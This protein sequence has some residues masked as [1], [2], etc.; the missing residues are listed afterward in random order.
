[1]F[2]FWGPRGLSRWLRVSI[3]LFWGRCG[4]PI[5]RRHDIISLV[6][7]PISGE[8]SAQQSFLT[9]LA[10]CQHFEVVAH[11]LSNPLGP[12][13]DSY[14][15]CVGD[16]VRKADIPSAEEVERVHEQVMAAIRSLFD[17]HKHLVPGWHEK[18][19]QIH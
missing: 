3:G 14:A 19:L 8:Q 1:M 6:G 7:R 9:V 4:L 12:W 10:A 11:Q 17:Q 18:E 2:S 15:F 16:A 5:P 13:T